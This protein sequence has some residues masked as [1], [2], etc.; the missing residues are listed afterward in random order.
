MS[1]LTPSD[2]L[3]AHVVRWSAGNW[4]IVA[5]GLLALVAA[6]FAADN[7]FGATYLQ[8]ADF[9]VDLKQHLLDLNSNFAGAAWLPMVML[10][11]L[12]GFAA[13]AHTLIVKQVRSGSTEQASSCSCRG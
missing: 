3:A 7:L 11:G 1:S 6:A 8:T 10:A 5:F 13:D 12:V 2:S 4:K 9:Q